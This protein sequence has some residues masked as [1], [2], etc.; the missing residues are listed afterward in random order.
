MKRVQI[1]SRQSDTNVL[2]TSPT[3]DPNKTYTLTVEKLIV[4][5]LDS[6]LLS[7]TL[8][9]IERRLLNGLNL[10][11]GN[12]S[13]PLDD[14]FTTFTPQNVR[15]ASQL[16]YQMNLFFS[17]M[18]KRLA[19]VVIGYNIGVHQFIVP[20]AFSPVQAVDW[21]TELVN[22]EPIQ[23]ALQAVF[24]P[25]GKIG[26]RFSVDG[27]K[28]FVIRLTSEGKRIFGRTSNYIAVDNNGNFTLDYD[29]G[30]LLP[31][32]A[33]DLPA[34][35]TDAYILICDNSLFSHINYRH[36][37][38]LE[39]SLPLDNTVEVDTDHSFYRRQLA[40]YRFPDH[41][42]SMKYTA[43]RDRSLVEQSQTMYVFEHDL[44]THNKFKVYGTDLQNFNFYLRSRRYEYDTNTR[45]YKQTST[46][47]ELHNDTF[48]TVQ[49]A[50]RPIK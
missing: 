6:L 33:L 31:Q 16:L 48:Y 37:L 44:K 38:V 3:L 2:L 24:Q 14:E 27:V 40:A 47:Y 7:D 39:T 25:D 17:E 13:L 50:L 20:P 26:F 8:F 35:I 4:P 42:T 34:Q 49:L 23:T 12:E 46:P 30:I 9:T 21:Y 43:V 22:P 45:K 29:V 15:T 5:A 1:N 19:T 36:E 32:V 41:N 18:C 28:L 11:G 10:F